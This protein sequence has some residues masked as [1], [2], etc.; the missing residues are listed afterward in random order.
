MRIEFPETPAGK[1]T[2]KN[3]IYGNIVGYVSGKRFWE[4]GSIDKCNE[5]TAKAWAQGES[6]EEAQLAILKED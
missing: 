4:F 1:R 5:A 3:N 2:V 6:L